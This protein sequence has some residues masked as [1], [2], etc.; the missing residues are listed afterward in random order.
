MESIDTTLLPIAT[1]LQLF[2][3]FSGLEQGNWSEKNNFGGKLREID[4]TSKDPSANIIWVFP[5]T[6]MEFFKLKTEITKVT[7]N[8]L[9]MYKIPPT[10]KI[11]LEEF[12]DFAIE[13][14]KGKCV[15]VYKL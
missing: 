7:I 5:W 6:K 13:R 8:R 15:S 1:F 10:N 2:A 11:S 4:R 3:T 9:Q 14:L 12:E